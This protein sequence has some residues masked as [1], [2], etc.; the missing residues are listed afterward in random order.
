MQNAEIHPNADFRLL[1]DAFQA[2][3]ERE[4]EWREGFEALGRDPETSNVEYAIPAAW[5]VVFDD[6]Q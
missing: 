2:E 6:E 3:R 4:Q 5:E 1:M